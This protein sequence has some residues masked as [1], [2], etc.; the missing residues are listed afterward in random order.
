LRPAVGLALALLLVDI[1]TVSAQQLPSGGGPLPSLRRGANGQIEIAPPEAA[2]R[3]PTGV[4]SRTPTPSATNPSPPR[5]DREVAAP[6]LR[7]PAPAPPSLPKGPRPVITVAPNVPSVP[8]TTPRGAVVATYS[9]KMSDNSPF[10]GTVRFG[11]PYYDYN[12]RFALRDN[13]IIVNPNGPGLGPNKKTNT[14]HVTLEAVP[15]SQ[16]AR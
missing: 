3:S 13:S 6:A 8:D 4:P 1:A 16:P 12:G 9:V 14:E 11:P 10:T 5:A 7:A 15:E 2:T